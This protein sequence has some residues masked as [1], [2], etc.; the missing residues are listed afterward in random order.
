MGIDSQRDRD[1][2]SRGR[3]A[4]RINCGLPADATDR[5]VEMACRG[6]GRM[7]GSE[8]ELQ[9]A[10]DLEARG[11]AAVRINCRLPADATNAE[12][13]RVCERWVPPSREDDY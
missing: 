12:V 11:R 1:V 13:K 4:V 10:R 7:G 8:R 5:E 2:E 6:L 3:A 9:A